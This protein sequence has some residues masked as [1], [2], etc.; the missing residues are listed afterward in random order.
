[1]KRKRDTG[2]FP[3]RPQLH[4]MRNVPGILKGSAE[5]RFADSGSGKPAGWRLRGAKNFFRSVTTAAPAWPLSQ[6]FHATVT[7]IKQNPGM[8][9]W[10]E[11]C[12]ERRCCVTRLDRAC[13]QKRA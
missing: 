13:R 1:M 6:P 9:F 7:C 2:R 5:G 4:L 8:E 3:L 11:I 12:H 10:G